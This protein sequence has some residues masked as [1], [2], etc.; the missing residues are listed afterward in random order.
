MPRGGRRSGTPGKTYAN[1]S[2]LTA[3]P[4]RT[5]P[6]QEYGQGVAQQNAQ[7]ALPLAQVSSVAAAPPSQVNPVPDPGMLSA[8]T[9]RPGEPVTAGL[10]IGAGPGPG[11]G[12]GDNVLADLQRVY[13][14]SGAEEVRQIIE[15]LQHERGLI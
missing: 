5:A 2:D 11:P 4:V 9:S 3:Q 13:A 10:P 12:Q 14:F 15:R 7:K 6:S 8:P 1:R